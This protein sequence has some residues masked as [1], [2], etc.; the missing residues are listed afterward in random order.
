[1]LKLIQRLA[2]L[3]DQPE[4]SDEQRV[5]HR[6]L[7]YMS[8]LMSGGGLVWGTVAVTARSRAIRRFRP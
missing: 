8:L 3:G 6:F 7:F 2:T 4:D 5:K 1:M